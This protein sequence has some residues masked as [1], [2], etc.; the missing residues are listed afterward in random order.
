MKNNKY[1]K[2]RNKIIFGLIL[3]VNFLGFSQNIDLTLKYNVTDNR[4]E[5]YARP[6]FT[7]NNFTWGP[8]QISVVLPAIIADTPLQNLTSYAAGNWGD[9]SIIYAP[10]VQPQNDFHGVESGGA[11]TNLVSGNE[12][13]IFS[14]T[15]N[16][17]CVPGLRI[18]NNGVD[19]DS[20]QPGLGGGAFSNTIENGMIYRKFSD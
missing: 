18:F 15:V 20:S 19:P 8:S 9:N 7:Q 2:M 5:V 1:T 11:L 3:L 10:S 16:G 6:D 13:L 17:G 4:Y 14:F 12:L